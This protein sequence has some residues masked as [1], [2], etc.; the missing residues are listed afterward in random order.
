MCLFSASLGLGLGG[1]CTI[2]RCHEDVRTRFFVR[3]GCSFVDRDALSNCYYV[4]GQTGIKS[5]EPGS[6]N[7]SYGVV[8]RIHY[9]ESEKAGLC[10]DTESMATI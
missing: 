2:V 8:R 3:G 4:V 1:R 9:V 6:Y 10:Y 7:V 5:E